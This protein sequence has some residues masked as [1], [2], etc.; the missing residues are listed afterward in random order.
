M[1]SVITTLLTSSRPAGPVGHG[2]LSSAIDWAANY[3]LKWVDKVAREDIKLVIPPLLLVRLIFSRPTNRSVDPSTSNNKSKTTGTSGAT[4]C[5]SARSGQAT[6]EAGIRMGRK[7]A[8]SVLYIRGLFF[9]SYV[10][11]THLFLRK[12]AVCPS[13]Y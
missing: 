1:F 2:S 9:I 5:S 11:H 7:M 4:S 10:P 3:I 13:E 12:H 6:A 8:E